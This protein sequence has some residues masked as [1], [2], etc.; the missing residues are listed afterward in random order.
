MSTKKVDRLTL[1]WA[2]GLLV[3]V[4]FVLALFLYGVCM[5][6]LHTYGQ[7]NGF[8]GD[9]FFAEHY[10]YFLVPSALVSAVTVYFGTR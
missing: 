8:D 10:L 7:F 1:V 6:T 9:A 2:F 4:W 5:F 3:I